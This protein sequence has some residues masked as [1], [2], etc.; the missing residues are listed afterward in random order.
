MWENSVYLLCSFFSLLPHAR[1]V[2]SVKMNAFF[3]LK[4]H[5]AG[6]NENKKKSL[7]ENIMNFCGCSRKSPQIFSANIYKRIHKNFLDLRK[8]W[9]PY[10]PLRALSFSAKNK[11]ERNS[12]GLIRLQFLLQVFGLPVTASEINNVFNVIMWMCWGS[13]P[14]TNT[15]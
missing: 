3:A 10:T 13:C 15:N 8:P 11:R 5:N 1:F 12:A 14:K 6:K 9:E 2:K 4:C 7:N